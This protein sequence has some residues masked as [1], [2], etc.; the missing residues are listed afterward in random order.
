M[1][2]VRIA[3]LRQKMQK[4]TAGR[5]A[6][7]PTQEMTALPLHYRGGFSECTEDEGPGAWSSAGPHTRP[8]VFLVSMYINDDD[9]YNK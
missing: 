3:L 5:K 2:I 4:G 1:S 8:Q 7:S 9:D 6:R